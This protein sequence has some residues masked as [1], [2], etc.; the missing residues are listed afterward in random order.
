[1]LLQFDLRSPELV[2]KLAV[3]RFQ[4]LDMFKIRLD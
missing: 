3:P 1:M 4:M 2:T